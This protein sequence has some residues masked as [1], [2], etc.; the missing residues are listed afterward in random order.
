MRDVLD[1]FM[2]QMFSFLHVNEY[3]EKWVQLEQFYIMLEDIVKGSRYQ[4]E[5]LLG[6]DRC[7]V[8]ELVDMM[9]IN[10]SPKADP[11]NKRYEMGS[12]Y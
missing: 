7:F 2:R 8:T 1:K 4:V 6:S 5:Y 9:L 11:N 12:D 10:K 3:Q